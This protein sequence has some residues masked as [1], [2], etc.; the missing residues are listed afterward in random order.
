MVLWGLSC[1]KVL[2][3]P[4]VNFYVFPLI[5]M[6]IFVLSSVAQVSALLCSCQSVNTS[7]FLRMCISAFQG[8]P[9]GNTCE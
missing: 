4:C 2:L 7:C 9:L 5:I 8:T 1:I 6:C 3:V